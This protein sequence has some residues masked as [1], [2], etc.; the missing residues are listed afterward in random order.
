MPS[1]HQNAATSSHDTDDADH[2]SASAEL[3]IE[4]PKFTSDFEQ[5]TSTSPPN[6]SISDS[7]K[8]KDPVFASEDVQSV[9]LSIVQGLPDDTDRLSSAISAVSAILAVKTPDFS[10]DFEQLSS[11]FDSANGE[12]E[13]SAE[14]EEVF[15]TRGALKEEGNSHTN[16]ADESSRADCAAAI[17]AIQDPTFS[18]NSSHPSG[19]QADTDNALSESSSE[20]PS[21]LNPVFSS[22]FELLQAENLENQSATSTNQDVSSIYAEEVIRRD[23]QLDAKS[24][25]IE[26]VSSGCSEELYDDEFEAYSKASSK[27]EDETFR[28]AQLRPA[29]SVGRS[30]IASSSQSCTSH[31]Q[32][33]DPE[34]E[35]LSN[36]DA[37]FKSAGSG[38]RSYSDTWDA[39][40]EIANYESAA[41]TMYARLR[42]AIIK[43]T[44][45]R[46]VN[47]KAKPELAKRDPALDA[48]R[49]RLAR[50]T[51]HL[52]SPPPPPAAQL[53]SK[54]LH[55]LRWQN[56]LRTL[57]EPI[58]NT[59]GSPPLSD[60]KIQ[61]QALEKYLRSR[62]TALNKK[63]AEEYV[64]APPPDAIEMI[65]EIA[66]GMPR[67]G[68][69]PS[70]WEIFRARERQNLTANMV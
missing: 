52:Q 50:N 17:P 43:S 22:D 34:V 9:N 49:S 20:I 69:G 15:Y 12:N 68:T 19:K 45:P 3:A 41:E 26:A 8:I 1:P 6:E 27:G 32:S 40:R 21:I 47:D 5:L 16:S 59:P 18:S 28:S 55:R 54:W 11:E 62:T 36:S 31:R 63:T 70:V 66:R 10:S 57:D 14:I 48:L 30:S 38:T 39:D 33:S 7:Y 67:T 51:Q 37:P 23:G 42:D 64:R 24:H 53:P 65:A 29:H 56:V 60:A 13:E 46:P 25:S 4:D 58:I 35:M 2:S 61:E 44:V